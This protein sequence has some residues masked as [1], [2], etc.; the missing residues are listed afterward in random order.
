M[1]TFTKAIQTKHEILF[2][3]LEA[4]TETDEFYSQDFTLDGKKYRVYNYRL[5][6][7]SDFLKPGAL[8]ARGT[9]FEIDD[10]GNPERLACLPM[11]KFFNLDE[12]PMTMGLDL[13]QIESIEVKS[14]GSLMSTYIHNDTLRLKSKGSLFSEQALDAMKWLE[15]PENSHLHRLLE[16]HTRN[17][18]T[19]NLEWVAPWNRIV[20]AYDTPRL[21]VLNRMDLV[22]LDWRTLS[23]DLT[24]YANPTVKPDEPMSVFASKIPDMQDDIEGFILVMKSGQRV[25]VKTKKY[26]SLHHA[27]DS[28]TN[29]RRLFEC[30]LDEATDDLRSMVAGDQ[31]AIDLIAKME[32]L[33]QHE[34]NHMV[35]VV[36]D[37]YDA[38]KGLDRKSYAIKGQIDLSAM[39][40]GLAMNLYVGRSNDYK[41]FMKSRYKEFGIR[42]SMTIDKE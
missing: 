33:V 34:Y 21:I 26:I 35:R 22:T 19:V 16:Y 27:K 2:R 8:M 25:K 39:T 28:I 1:I 12:N 13:T 10:A 6:S 5:A 38:N 4:L 36:E 23:S 3:S 40:F 18:F 29:P 14:D 15:K 32:Q 11:P 17:G 37:F 20:L 24:E 30:V 9:M 31:V 42:D 7:Y 41:T